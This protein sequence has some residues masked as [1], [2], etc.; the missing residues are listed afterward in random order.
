MSKVDGSRWL[1]GKKREV[2]FSG[3]A[4]AETFANTQN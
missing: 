1:D 3:F 4:E 2:D